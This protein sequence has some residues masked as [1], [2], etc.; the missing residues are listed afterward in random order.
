MDDEDIET[1][2]LVRFWRAIKADRIERL[3]RAIEAQGMTFEGT[4]IVAGPER[5]DFAREPQ[6]FCDLCNRIKYETELMKG[7][8]EEEEAARKAE[9]AH[10]EKEMRRL[11]RELQEMQATIRLYAAQNN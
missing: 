2:D 1:E 5:L 4:V 10:H 11:R 7:Q 3:Y 6:V 8:R 9:M